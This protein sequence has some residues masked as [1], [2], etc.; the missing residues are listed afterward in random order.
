MYL[1][2]SY[3]RSVQPLWLSM[4][5]WALWKSNQA[6]FWFLEIWLLRKPAIFSEPWRSPEHPTGSGPAGS[7]VL[8]PASNSTLRDYNQSLE[9]VHWGRNWSL[10]TFY[11]INNRDYVGLF[12]CFCYNEEF[13]C[14]KNL[15]HE[16]KLS[17]R[18]N[19]CPSLEN[20]LLWHENFS[21]CFNGCV[22]QNFFFCK[23]PAKFF[24]LCRLEAFY[25]ICSTWPP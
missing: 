21:S 16:E 17:N 8:G 24:G 7:T 9:S 5:T 22:C 20:I 2:A 18:S 23:G 19:L 14:C 1:W 4:K 13:Y 25:V 6:I 10:S 12:V 15:R 3:K 11:F